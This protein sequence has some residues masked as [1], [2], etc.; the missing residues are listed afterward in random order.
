M[1]RNRRPPNGDR[2]PLVP[3]KRTVSEEAS[4]DT[5]DDQWCPKMDTCLH[6]LLAARLSAAL[7]S[8]ISDCDETFNYWEPIHF[9]I[10]GKGFQTWEY[11]PEFGLRSYFYILLHTVPAWVYERLLNPHPLFVFYF[12]RCLLGMVSAFCEAYFVQAVKREA[13]A[14][15]ARL[16]LAMLALSAGMFVASTA[17]LPSTTSMYLLMLSM[18]AWFNGNM[19]LAILFTAMSAFLSWP[20]AAVL[21]VPIALDILFV[22]FKWLTFF[23]WCAISVATILVPQIAMD[24]SYYGRMTVAPLNIVMY[25]IFTPHGPDLYGT[26]PWTFYFVNGFLNFNVVFFLALVSLPLVALV[27]RLLPKQTRGS[28][29]ISNSIEFL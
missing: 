19:Q 9:F 13:G 15:A 23:R 16:T 17:L 1:V 8:T 7:W 27:N 5:Y 22:R 18:G 26:E 24:T 11:S 10:Y 25:N 20:F 14:I 4:N 28:N 6:L 3:P 2:K 21:G 12:L 29:N